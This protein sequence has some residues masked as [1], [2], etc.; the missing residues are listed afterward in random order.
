[1]ATQNNNIS[2]EGDPIEEAKGLLDLLRS[3]IEDAPTWTRA[4]VYGAN[5]LIREIEGRLDRASG[6]M[7]NREV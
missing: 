6:L 2:V 4:T 3:A 1:M 5:T 7:P